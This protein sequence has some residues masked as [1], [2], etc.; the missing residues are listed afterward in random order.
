MPRY[1]TVTFVVVQFV[2]FN[3]M[4]VTLPVRLC[5]VVT[6]LTVTLTVP[7]V[8]IIIG[9]LASLTST[10]IVTLPTVL[11]TIPTVV[12]VGILLTLYVS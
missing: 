12:F 3:L 2:M 5:C 4:L 6:L 1:T 11:L 9:S 10:S 7:L 8:I